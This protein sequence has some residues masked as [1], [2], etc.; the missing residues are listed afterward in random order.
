MSLPPLLI[1][2]AFN[3]GETPHVKLRDTRQRVLHHMEGLLAW[4]E[5][6]EFGP[7]VFAKSLWHLRH[8]WNNRRAFRGACQA[9]GRGSGG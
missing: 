6:A 5:G 9:S 7:I 8:A 3:V 4:L 2:A 1:T